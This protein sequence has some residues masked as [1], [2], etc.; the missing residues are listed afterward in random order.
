MCANYAK[1]TPIL[2]ILSNIT[3]S[4]QS[5]Y[6]SLHNFGQ[7]NSTYFYLKNL[8]LMFRH[9]CTNLGIK[10]PFYFAKN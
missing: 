2:M 8:S 5:S 6:V 3:P 10:A 1:Y 7:I 9:F 4:S